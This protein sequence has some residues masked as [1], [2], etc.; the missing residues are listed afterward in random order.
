V[1]VLQKNRTVLF[2]NHLVLGPIRVGMVMG[3]TVLTLTLTCIS[4][5]TKA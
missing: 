4:S 1:G 2:S 3:T 5:A